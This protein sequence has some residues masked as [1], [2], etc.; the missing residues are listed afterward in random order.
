MAI[1]MKEATSTIGNIALNG[2]V[3]K[4]TMLIS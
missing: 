4:G 2:G 1:E 3:E